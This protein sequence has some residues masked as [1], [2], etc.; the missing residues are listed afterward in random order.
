[1]KA[2]YLSNTDI[3]KYIDSLTLRTLFV[4][5]KILD[6]N[7]RPIKTIEG[8]ATG[9]SISINAS[10]AVRRTGNITLV[11]SESEIELDEDLK[12][13]YKVTDVDNLI[14]MNKR[15]EIEIGLKNT[16]LEYKE[17]DTFW[18]PLG[19]FLITNASVTHNLQGIQIQ[20]K[21][22]DK[23]ALLNG[24]VGGTIPGAIIHSPY[25]DLLT[26]EKIQALFF[27]L[28]R[29]LVSEIGE[30]P[31]HKIIIEDIGERITTGAFWQNISTEENLELVSY[32]DPVTGTMVYEIKQENKDY[33][34][35]KAV[36][37]MPNVRVG[38]LNTNFVYPDKELSS[39][40]G[41]SVASMLDKI[42]KALGN[43]EY[44][45][46]LD[47]NFRFRQIKNYLNEGSAIDDITVAIAEGYF[48]NSSAG[49]SL[50]SFAEGVNLIS[51]Y[52][53]NPTY[54]NIKNDYTV[55][56]KKRGTD[57]AIRYHLI[58]DNK[59]LLNTE[60]Q[61]LFQGNDSFNVWLATV[62]D[63]TQAFPTEQAART[64]VL[65]SLNI[66]PNIASMNATS[67]TFGRWRFHDTIIPE[68]MTS[69]AKEGDVNIITSKQVKFSLQN[70]EQNEN[71]VAIR[72]YIENDQIIIEF[73]AIQNNTYTWTRVYENKWK[74]EKY[75]AITFGNSDINLPQSFYQ[76]LTYNAEYQ[77]QF[78]TSGLY[79]F[80][81]E[82][83]NL[84]N[85]DLLSWNTE[86]YLYDIYTNA[87]TTEK[88]FGIWIQSSS[89]SYKNDAGEWFE[90]YRNGEWN[91]IK[92]KYLFFKNSYHIDDNNYNWFKNYTFE[93]KIL[94]AGERWQFN[95]IIDLENFPGDIS[96]QF[97]VFETIS[98][99]KN[100]YSAAKFNKIIKQ[101]SQLIA[102]N[103][104]DLNKQE[105]MYENGQWEAPDARNN[106]TNDSFQY[107]YIS[108]DSQAIPINAYNWLIQNAK[109]YT[110][111]YR[112]IN[113]KWQLKATNF[114]STPSG[115][116][117][118]NI[119]NRSE[120]ITY[121]IPFN[122]IWEHQY[123][124]GTET[125]IY[126]GTAF[127]IETKYDA[128]YDRKD[129]PILSVDYRISSSSSTYN[130][131]WIDMRSSN[132]G[133][134]WRPEWKYIDFGIG[135]MV[136]IYFY[137]WFTAN[138][139]LVEEN[140]ETDLVTYNLRKTT[141]QSQEYIQTGEVWKL[142]ENPWLSYT[143]QGSL[144]AGIWF[145]T[146]LALFFDPITEKE[147]DNLASIDSID[148]TI[149]S[150]N[151]KL[152]INNKKMIYENNQ[153]K[154]APPIAIKFLQPITDTAFFNVWKAIAEKYVTTQTVAVATQK[155]ITKTQFEQL[156]WRLQRYYY[157]VM[158]CDISYLGKEMKENIPK[159]FNI[160]DG[161]WKS[162]S[163][164]E[165]EY[166]IDMIDL[167][168]V[169]VTNDPAL[170]GTVDSVTKKK[171]VSQSGYEALA[172]A[173]EFAVHKI[174]RRAKV[175]DSQEVNCLFRTGSEKTASQ[176]DWTNSVFVLNEH[177][178]S[179]NANETV[180]AQQLQEEAVKKGQL[181][182]IVPKEVFTR[183]SV[184]D[185]ETPAYDL[186]RSQL[187]E[188]L[189]YNENINLTAVPVYHLDVNTRI[190][191]EDDKSDIHGDYLIQSI[192]IPLTINGQMTINAK[193][194][195]ER[196]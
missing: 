19:Q 91:E 22:T 54:S 29:E 160:Q 130:N 66:D 21:L 12:T 63:I 111:P 138:F 168:D 157:Y 86:F 24:E 49:K 2:S 108:G 45:F 142:K 107:F 85:N 123:Y 26:G 125:E 181:Q 134:N 158:T 28:I 75:R 78:I 17:Y 161:T 173:Y 65:T 191:V 137:N 188:F 14:S 3:L 155:T 84:P 189:S 62:S 70:D 56:G 128:T 114:F 64:A 51:S 69:F 101:N 53:N 42:A 47:G 187:H 110:V 136:S 99:T 190:T 194:A 167:D 171:Y 27:T 195:I 92:Y 126:L 106:N 57:T 104:Y 43:F 23:M 176:I 174:Q 103:N 140:A 139:E 162:S 31:E 145:T 196:I 192:Q 40:S 10:S 8:R 147:L 109:Q 120:Q 153:W 52:S 98:G 71:F 129:G 83:F 60:E 81:N 144:S 89:I 73:N 180:L 132:N 143:N 67:K 90:V 150:T 166:F 59:K 11:A 48:I 100:Y 133:Y 39:T 119:A 32:K 82:S 184:L 25:E 55:W 185:P 163:L 178:P 135:Q 4:R 61:Q 30:I 7:E 121:N 18:M 68:V 58:I 124:W 102:Q 6:K 122:L 117:N 80:N 141:A 15:V 172:K 177:D 154:V 127:K 94:T 193:R 131:E 146:P 179:L 37:Y 165:R 182:V 116:Y 95:N 88:F 46:D 9:G 79:S 93:S 186:L 74:E 175:I 38:M 13:L 77:E 97:G 149:G 33:V 105:I 87:E 72:S 164:T 44:F 118:F 152:L 151:N 1:M 20:V 50:Y 34:A 169:L 115:Y 36:S 76:W 16:G 112:E 113:G 35:L 5:M 41:D 148:I 96:L 170:I 159:L 183:L 156:D